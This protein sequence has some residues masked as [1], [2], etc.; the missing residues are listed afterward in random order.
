MICPIRRMRVTLTAISWA[1]C[2][3]GTAVDIQRPT[4]GASPAA[5]AVARAPTSR[6]AIEQALASIANRKSEVFASV[7]ADELE[8]LRTQLTQIDG[9]L[10]RVRQQMDEAMLTGT[11]DSK[12][13]K[14]A[15]ARIISQMQGVQILSLMGVVNTTGYDHPDHKVPLP[16]LDSTRKLFSVLAQVEA[17][18]AALD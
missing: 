9:Q 17:Q 13:G 14:L 15:A 7:A 11:W 18:L 4:Y 16:V 12:D 1:L 10:R 6:A 2:G 3:A 5:S 8:Q